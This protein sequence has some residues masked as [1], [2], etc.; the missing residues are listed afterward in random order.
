[1]AKKI[2]MTKEEQKLYNELVKLAK[3]ANQRIV[4]LERLTGIKESFATKQLADYLSAYPVQGW[5]TKGRVRVSKNFTETQMISIIKATTVFLE[6][7]ENSLISGIKKQKKEV[8]KSIG[9]PITYSQ[10]NTLYNASE[11]YKWAN[12]EF[13]SKFWKDF[14]PLVFEKT[15]NEW[16]EYCAT[17]IDKINDLTVKDRLKVL[18]DYLKE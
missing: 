6:D 5:S 2:E 7:I 17:Y 18:Y 3:R 8:E 16:V 12:D 15:K 11:L 9:K 1:M 4:R 13:G 14:A 10:L